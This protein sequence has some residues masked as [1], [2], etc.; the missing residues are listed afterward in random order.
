MHISK[1]CKLSMFIPFPL[2]DISLIDLDESDIPKRH[3]Y[4]IYLPFI[5]EIGSE[6]C[7]ILSQ[8][9]Q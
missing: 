5:R 7:A 9:S 3:K 8:K 1:Q 4:W 6:H 2:R